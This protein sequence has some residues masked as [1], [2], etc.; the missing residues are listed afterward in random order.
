[1]YLDVGNEALE[2]NWPEDELFKHKKSKFRV[3]HFSS[4]VTFK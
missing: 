3:R 2:M 1:M 4:I